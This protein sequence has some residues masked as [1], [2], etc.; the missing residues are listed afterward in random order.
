MAKRVS[1]MGHTLRNGISRDYRHMLAESSEEDLRAMESAL[2]RRLGTSKS[3]N[4][5]AYNKLG[6]IRTELLR[7]SPNC[8]KKVEVKQNKG[9]V[10]GS[11]WHTV[12]VRED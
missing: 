6:A 3:F 11:K 8:V 10:D 4:T 5:S 12:A 7:R 9:V 2:K 1:Y